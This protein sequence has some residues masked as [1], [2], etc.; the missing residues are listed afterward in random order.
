MIG[1]AKISKAPRQGP[2]SSSYDRGILSCYLLQLILLGDV[3]LQDID[4][5]LL[6]SN[7]NKVSTRNMYSGSSF[8]DSGITMRMESSKSSYW[9]YQTC[10]K[11]S[12][13]CSLCYQ[14]CA[15]SYVFQGLHA[16]GGWQYACHPIERGVG[17]NYFAR[18][19]LYLSFFPIAT[20][21]AENYRGCTSFWSGVI[22]WS[23]L[24]SPPRIRNGGLQRVS[25]QPAQRWRTR[26][27]TSPALWRHQWSS[28]GGTRCLFSWWQQRIAIW[29]DLMRMGIQRMTH[30]DLHRGPCAPPDGE[31]LW[32]PPSSTAGWT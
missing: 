7:G 27:T 28:W 29:N 32:S 11:S 25:I 1:S 12:S 8:W 4:F 31:L 20:S 22:V 15:L 23:G 26:N 5:S 2:S 9:W 21:I 18:S 6:V 3:W 19:L 13:A 16:S 30:G 17:V 10:N 14:L 24:C